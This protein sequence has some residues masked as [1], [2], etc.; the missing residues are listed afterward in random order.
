MAVAAIQRSFSPAGSPRFLRSW[1]IS[2]A[3]Q[4][5]SSSRGRTVKLP[6][7][8]SQSVRRE[9]PRAN[10][11]LVTTLI[12]IFSSGCSRRK[13]WAGPSCLLRRSRSSATKRVESQITCPKVS[14][15]ASSS[16]PHPRSFLCHRQGT[17]LCLA[18]GGRVEREDP[19]RSFQGPPWRRQRR[20][21]ETRLAPSRRGRLSGGNAQNFGQI[22]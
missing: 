19:M 2:A 20:R 4:R 3:F 7:K 1:K 13:R 6:Q 15:R 17:D 5:T 9:N 14:A 12:S 8:A 10:S 18:S 16:A 11:P 22:P 21:P